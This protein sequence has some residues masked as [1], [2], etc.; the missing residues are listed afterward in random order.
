MES[1]LKVCMFWS[2]EEIQVIMIAALKEAAGKGLQ[3][4][5]QK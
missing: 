5:L 2:S 1:I 3:Q 4:S